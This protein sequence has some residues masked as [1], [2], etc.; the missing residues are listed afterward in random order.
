VRSRWR[1]L[2]TRARRAR[3]IVAHGA[4]A[5][6]TPTASSW[7]RRARRARDVA[8]HSHGTLAASPLTAPLDRARTARSRRQRPQRARDVV[9][10]SRRPRGRVSARCPRGGAPG[11]RAR[12]V[13][14]HGII[15]SA[16]PDGALPATS[17][18]DAR[19]ARS[20]HRRVRRSRP[21]RP[22]LAGGVVAHGPLG[23]SLRAASSRRSPRV[24]LAAAPPDGA[25]PASPCAPR[26]ELMA[27]TALT[28][29]TLALSPAL[30]A[31]RWTAPPFGCGGLAAYYQSGCGGHR[32]VAYACIRDCDVFCSLL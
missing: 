14:A 17:P 18:D 7:R 11:R 12:D 9:A 16:A 5:A 30:T 24:A 21:R 8:T 32:D 10:H 1:P 23:A 25:L 29:R 31:R 22:R 4:P 3:G 15:V 28:R 19:M 13:A 27:M 20:R 6:S 26:D 2:T